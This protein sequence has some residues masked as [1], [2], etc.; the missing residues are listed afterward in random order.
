[1]KAA[2]NTRLTAAP[3]ICTG[4]SMI[5]PRNSGMSPTG[6]LME[7]T[8]GPKI[9]IAPPSISDARPIVAMITA[10]VGRPSN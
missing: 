6:M 2:R 8:P 10:T 4:C 7:R 1:M 5:G 3:A 9:S